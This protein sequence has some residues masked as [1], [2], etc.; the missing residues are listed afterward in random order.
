MSL[1]FESS[2]AEWRVELLT[3][4]SSFHSL[5]LSQMKVWKWWQQRKG[6]GEGKVAQRAWEWR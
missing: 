1:R 6:V 2:S 5:P 4:V 3:A